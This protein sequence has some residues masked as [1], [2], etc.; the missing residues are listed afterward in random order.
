M[1]SFC[2]ICASFDGTKN[3]I[4][5]ETHK[6]NCQLKNNEKKKIKWRK[7]LD[8]LA[9]CTK[10]TRNFLLLNETSFLLILF[11]YLKCSLCLTSHLAKDFYILFLYLEIR[12]F[13]YLLFI[14]V[15]FNNTNLKCKIFFIEWYLIRFWIFW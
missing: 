3:W 1:I 12:L 15:K 2:K 6:A 11:A 4:W 14:Y 13:K 8:F 9:D 10:Q 7:H 5:C